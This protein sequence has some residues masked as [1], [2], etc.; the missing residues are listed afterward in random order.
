MD[1]TLTFKI[2]IPTEEI[3]KPAP[4]YSVKIA[5]LV[6]YKLNSVKYLY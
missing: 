6:Q 2:R 1:D 3:Q 4:Y 5:R